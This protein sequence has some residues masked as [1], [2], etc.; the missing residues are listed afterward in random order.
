MGG[1]QA[2]VGQGGDLQGAASG[3][4]E[5]DVDGLV[6]QLPVGG[7]EVA[8]ALDLSEAEGVQV[9]V[10]LADDRFGDGL[11]DAVFVGFLD[12]D[13]VLDRVAGE[14]SGEGVQ[15]SGAAAVVDQLEEAADER[16]AL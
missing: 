6:E 13:A 9:G 15:L 11:A 16:A 3:V 10:E 1:L 12:A 14:G 7:W 8:A 4:A 2:V 5:Q